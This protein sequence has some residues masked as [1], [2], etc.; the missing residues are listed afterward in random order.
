MFLWELRQFKLPDTNQGFFIDAICI[1]QDHIGERGAQV[2]I[3]AEIYANAKCVHAWLGPAA[4]D[5]DSLIEACISDRIEEL[6]RKVEA[7]ENKQ[8]YQDRGL[9]SVMHV[10]RLPSILALFS[11]TYWDRL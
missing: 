1:D 4:A 7:I 9:P 3:M 5:S 8:P 10:E 11:R 6:T 2:Q